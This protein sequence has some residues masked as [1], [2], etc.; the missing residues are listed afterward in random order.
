MINR[1]ILDEIMKLPPNGDDISLF[2]TLAILHRNQ[3][4]VDLLTNEKNEIYYSVKVPSI[5][6]S[7]IDT[8][9]LMDLRNA[10]WEYSED[11]QFIIKKI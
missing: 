1:F 3:I 11:K 2:S 6:L 9:D 5:L 4:N 8:D 7:E 10:K